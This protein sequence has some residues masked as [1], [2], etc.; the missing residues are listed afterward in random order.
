MMQAGKVKAIGVMSKDRLPAAPDVPTF[1]ENGILGLDVGTWNVIMAP[2]RTP[3]LVANQLNSAI[4]QVLKDPGIRERLLAMSGITPT[5]DS[6][7]ASTAERVGQE[8]DKWAK[9]FKMAGATAQ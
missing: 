8:I 1:E 5:D 9:A 7:P 6:T 4:N 3:K 2:A